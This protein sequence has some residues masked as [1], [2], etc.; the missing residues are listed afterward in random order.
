ANTSRCGQTEAEYS[1][2]TERPGVSLK[3]I[4]GKK[5]KCP[6]IICVCVCVCVCI[7]YSLYLRPQKSVFPYL[8]LYQHMFLLCIHL[9]LM[10]RFDGYDYFNRS[11]VKLL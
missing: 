5:P 11:V 9:K 10:H 7:S 3:N 6:F 8:S 1:T 4:C 2:M